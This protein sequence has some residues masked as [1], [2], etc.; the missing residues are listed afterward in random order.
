MDKEQ[1]QAILRKG[2]Q[3]QQLSLVIISVLTIPHPSRVFLSCVGS[4]MGDRE[5]LVQLVGV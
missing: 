5:Y 4:V 2:S 3:K 1:E